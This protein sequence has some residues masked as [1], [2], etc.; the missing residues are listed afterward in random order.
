MLTY[1]LLRREKFN[2]CAI[3][4]ICD[5]IYKS[6]EQSHKPKFSVIILSV[7]TCFVRKLENL[8]CLN[9]SDEGM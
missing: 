2:I 6:L 4:G 9:R 3:H 1:I 5:L 7:K 8:L